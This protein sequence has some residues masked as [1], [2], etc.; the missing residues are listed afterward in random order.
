MLRRWQ[1]R[2][3]LGFG[4]KRPRQP[5]T[6]GRAIRRAGARASG[7]RG[8]ALPN[9]A[10]LDQGGACGAAARR[11]RG[12]R[13]WEARPA[14]AGHAARPPDQRGSHVRQASAR[15]AVLPHRSLSSSRSWPSPS[16]DPETSTSASARESPGACETQPVPASASTAREAT[17]AAARSPSNPGPD[18]QPHS[19]RSAHYRVGVAA[20]DTGRPR[21]GAAGSAGPPRCRDRADPA[22]GGVTTP[23]QARCAATGHGDRWD[24]VGQRQP[25]A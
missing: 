13:P 10:V 25:E 20:L 24:T 19:G 18:D 11:Q 15:P 16:Q 21:C 17:E 2:P 12:L 22:D 5:C 9:L 14:R 4:T 3:V 8:V 7:A 6:P 23:L 1:S